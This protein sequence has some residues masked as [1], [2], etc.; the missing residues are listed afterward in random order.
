V[1]SKVEIGAGTTSTVGFLVGIG[2]TKQT[3][4]ITW[5]TIE[6]AVLTFPPLQ[7]DLGFPLNQQNCRVFNGFFSRGAISSGTGGVLALSSSILPF[8]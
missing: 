1:E 7:R 8:R 5:V 3:R 4:D 2:E 6:N